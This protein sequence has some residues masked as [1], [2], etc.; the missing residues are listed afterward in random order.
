MHEVADTYVFDEEDLKTIEALDKV[1]VTARNLDGCGRC[2]AF[3]HA[4]CWDILMEAVKDENEVALP[5]C[6]PDSGDDDSST[7]DD[8]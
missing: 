1:P 2:G 3:Y 6:N 8:N 4:K 5:C 7:D